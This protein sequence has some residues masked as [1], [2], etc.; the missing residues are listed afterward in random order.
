M[1]SA[2][3][4][5]DF[6]LYSELLHQYATMTS[7]IGSKRSFCTSNALVFERMEEIKALQEEF[8]TGL[9]DIGA[10]CLSLQLYYC[11]C[12]RRVHFSSTKSQANY[13]FYFHHGEEKEGL[14][15]YLYTAYYTDTFN[16]IMF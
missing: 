2:C 3:S 6:V 9:V 8:L 14:L 11:D 16:R 10:L 7:G 4:K 15:S 12:C 1:Q 5:S 13:R